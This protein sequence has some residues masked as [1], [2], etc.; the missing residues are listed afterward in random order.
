MF[1]IECVLYR[2][3]VLSKVLLMSTMCTW[4][5]VR[6]YWDVSTMLSYGLSF[7]PCVCGLQC[8]YVTRVFICECLYLTRV[9]ICECLYVT[10]VFVCECLYV[11]RVFICD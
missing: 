2:I 6:G 1:S 4:P 10:R 3:E 9:F 8:L 11:T 5:T 7:T